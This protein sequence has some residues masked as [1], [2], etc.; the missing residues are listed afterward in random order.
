MEMNPFAPSGGLPHETRERILRGFEAWLDSAL[1]GEE[2][3]QGVAAD[4]LSVLERGDPLPPIEGHCDLYSLWSAM[5]ALTQEVKLQSRTFRQLNDTLSQATESSG[6]ATPSNRSAPQA[7]TVEH[8]AA[9]PETERRSQKQQVDLLLDLRDRLD[10][11]IRS[12]REAEAQLVAASGR[13]LLARWFGV[14]RGHMRQTQDTVAAL[15]KGYALT[16][17]RLDQALQ[18]YHLSPILCEGQVFDPHRMTAVELEETDSVPEGTV[19]GVYRS[20][21]EWEGEIYRSAQVKVARAPREGA[22]KERE[23]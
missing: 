5:T 13:S 21:Y 17:D 8:P 16:L 15:E 11:G 18:D 7:V 10:R 19:V 14:G 9:Q 22:Q 1:V 6:G 4:L 20:G 12:V 23:I 2:L 3:L